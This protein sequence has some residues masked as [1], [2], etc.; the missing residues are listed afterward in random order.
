MKFHCVLPSLVCVALLSACASSSTSPTAEA[1]VAR[2]TS[3]KAA[4]AEANAAALSGRPDKA[5]TLLKQASITYP[6]DKAPW[7]RMAQMRFDSNNYGDAIVNALEALRRDPDDTLANSVVAVSGL[8][9]SSKAL[10]DLTR[11]NN[12]SGSVRTEAQ[13][14]ARLLRTSLGEDTLFQ[15]EQRTTQ[16]KAATRSKTTTA[17][18]ATTTATSTSSS[19]SNSSSSKSSG[20]PFGALK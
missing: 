11:K 3:V 20:D 17:S 9:L 2:T 14:L 12:L 18:A 16:P 7:V 19:N 13:D 10:S 6:N 1:P 15:K 5:Y 4:M 8:R